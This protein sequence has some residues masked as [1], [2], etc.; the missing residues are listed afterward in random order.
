VPNTPAP[1]PPCADP[2]NTLGPPY[3]GTIGNESLLN[4]SGSAAVGTWFIKVF[5]D[6]GTDPITLG[7]VT[8]TGGLIA[9]PQ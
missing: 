7:A 1:P 6:A 2:D 4:F 8:V 5:R 3:F 9:K